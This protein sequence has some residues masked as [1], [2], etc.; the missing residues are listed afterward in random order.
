MLQDQ[1]IIPENT[2]FAI[3]VS[4]ARTFAEANGISSSSSSMRP[5]SKKELASLITNATH[6]IGCWAIGE[7]ARK[8][9]KGNN[10]KLKASP[11]MVKQVA[12][13]K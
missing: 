1:G 12:S 9:R 10:L 13:F 5:I 2:N 3:K 7:E 11:S 4:V 8:I 6:L